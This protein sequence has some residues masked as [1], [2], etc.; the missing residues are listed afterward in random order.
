MLVDIFKPYTE[1][2]YP[3]LDP[4][5]VAKCLDFKIVVRNSSGFRTSKKFGNKI[6]NNL[7]TSNE[8]T[9]I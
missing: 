3:V 2:K 5:P 1:G 4:E 7:I 9:F 6:A 8:E